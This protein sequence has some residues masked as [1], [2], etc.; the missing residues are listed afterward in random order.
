M[1]LPKEVIAAIIALVGVM[2]SI[3]ISFV[4]SR[5][6]IKLEL[7][8]LRLQAQQTYE[9][10]LLE[11]RLTVYP[12]AYSYLSSFI[13]EAQ[14][15]GLSRIAVETLLSKL[16]EWDSKNSLFLSGDASNTLHDFRMEFFLLS[17]RASQNYAPSVQDFSCYT[18]C[19]VLEVRRDD[20]A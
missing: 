2:L 19:A 1:E 3:F 4:T 11:I 7:R 8:K 18:H 14:R 5:R 13:K 9:S 12:E 6:A 16:D 15:N 17:R 10:K 20:R